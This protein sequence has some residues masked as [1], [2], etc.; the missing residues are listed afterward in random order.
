MEPTKQ[1][2]IN[3]GFNGEII[4]ANVKRLKNNSEKHE[5]NEVAE[6][7]GDAQGTVII[8]TD[9]E[10]SIDFLIKELVEARPEGRTIVENSLDQRSGNNG[11]VEKAA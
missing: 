11:I 5:G 6:E 9:Q 1:I 10:P 8:K 3:G 2:A 7:N 4:L